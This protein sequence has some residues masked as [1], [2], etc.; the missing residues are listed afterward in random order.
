MKVNT[1]KSK[2]AE[3]FYIKHSYID[4]NGKSTSRTIRKLGTL[5]ELLVEHGPTRD[6]V[7]EWAREQARM[8]TEK[9]E[10]EKENYRL[11]IYFYP[12]RKI[13]HGEKR[14][15]HGGYLFLQ[16][17]YYQLNLDQICRKIRTR[18]NYKYDLNAIL[19]D[20]IYTR[21]LDPGSK[22]SSFQAAKKFLEPPRIRTT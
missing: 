7:M 18:H 21:I 3:S 9:Y 22:R 19:S 17:I 20:L 8:E 11:P 6:D 4:A 5:K 1:S 14:C 10:Q 2:N 13:P 15:F 12:N 16:S